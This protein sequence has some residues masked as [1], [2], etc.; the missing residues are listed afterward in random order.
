[1]NGCCICRSSTECVN[2]L[3]LYYSVA[4]KDLVFV[5]FGVKWVMSR[6]VQELL[7]C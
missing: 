2:N 5:V 4:K 6:M 1:M 3:L 7:Q